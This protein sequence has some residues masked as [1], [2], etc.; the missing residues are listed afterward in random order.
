MAGSVVLIRGINVGA[1]H[2]VRMAELVAACE[3]ASLGRPRAYLQSGNLVFDAPAAG[4]PAP[5]GA[6][7]EDPAAGGGGSG[8]AAAV[9]TDRA[10]AVAGILAARFGVTARCLTVGAGRL[11]AALRS[12][13][14]DADPDE[15]LT[16]LVFWDPPGGDG[17]VAR[18]AAGREEL[19]AVA[20]EGAFGGDRLVL[21]PDH[22]VVLYRESSRNSKLG[23]PRLER[24]LGVEG[25]A[26]NLRTTRVLA[27][28]CGGRAD[29]T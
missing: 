9:G 3:A 24:A 20:E 4:V 26:R 11:A 27:E 14:E 12:V 28:W 22:A 1:H 7:A 17:D 19:L 13:P 15:K 25:T 16:H 29:G 18:F 10:D 2:R 21:E 5:G 8:D 6:G 23:L